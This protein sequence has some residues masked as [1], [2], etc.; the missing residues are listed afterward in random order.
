MLKEVV[1]QHSNAD[2]SQKSINER[3]GKEVATTI[4]PTKEKRF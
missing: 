2:I 3:H 4:S 1:G